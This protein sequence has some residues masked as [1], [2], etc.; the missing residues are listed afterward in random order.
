MSGVCFIIHKVCVI[1]GYCPGSYTD[2]MK[3]VAAILAGGSGKRFGGDTPK[4]F[5]KVYGRAIIEYTVDAF[6]ENPLIDEI[7]VVVNNAYINLMK[8]IAAENK[9][10]KLAAILPGGRERCDSSLCAIGYYKGSDMNILIHDGARPMVNQRMITQTVQEL[11][12]FS[13]VC[14][15]C[16]ATD[17]IAVSD[18]GNSEIRYIPPR[19]LMYQVQTPQGFSLKTIAQAYEKALKDPDFFATDDCG[20]VKAYLPDVQI[21]IV[22]GSPENIKITRQKDLE[23]LQSFNK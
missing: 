17:T 14:C 5:V 13:A 7:C 15:A 11:A 4:Q 21:K 2:I 1:K 9:W 8:E 3:T 18:D 19:H 12:H 16:P 6:E 20:V 22:E 10:K 23:I